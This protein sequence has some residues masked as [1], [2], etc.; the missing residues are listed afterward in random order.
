MGGHVHTIWQVRSVVCLSRPPRSQ[1]SVW[2]LVRCFSRCVLSRVQHSRRRQSCTL[3]SPFLHSRAVWFLL[4]QKRTVRRDGYAC[5]LPSPGGIRP[6]PR[7]PP[8]PGQPTPASTE[9]SG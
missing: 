3:R 1:S 7:P 2:G 9:L 4:E 6:Q 5:P 8:L